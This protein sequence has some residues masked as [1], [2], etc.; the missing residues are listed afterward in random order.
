M[1]Y[2]LPNQQLVSFGDAVQAGLAHAFDGPAITCRGVQ[3][4]PDGG[5]G[6]VFGVE[7]VDAR[8]MPERQDWKGAPGTKWGVGYWR[9]S[10]PGPADLAR[11]EQ[12]GGHAVRLADGHEWLIPVARYLDGGTAFPE[13]LQLGP[14]GQ[15]A[16]TG[17]IPQYA[18]ICR[19]AETAWA[20]LSTRLED[21]E[22]GTVEFTLH[23]EAQLAAQALGVN[24]RVGPVECS[25]LG[26]FDTTAVSAVVLALVD[27]PSVKALTIA[28]EKK[29]PVGAGDSTVS[30][31]RD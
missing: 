18:D 24:Y 9:S 1:L 5:A 16:Q 10:K 30:G 20:A 4:G 21:D 14:D 26:L 29:S 6:A 23:D 13:R 19:Q 22:T 28:E 31:V 3:R 15:W 8:Y 7:G 17:T 27:W 12:I 25:L 2:Y 11:P